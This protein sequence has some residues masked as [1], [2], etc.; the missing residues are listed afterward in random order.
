M[1]HKDFMLK[2]YGGICLFTLYPSTCYSCE[3]EHNNF[4][5]STME[6]FTLDALKP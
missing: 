1:I 6:N 2:F 4:L 5:L 3:I